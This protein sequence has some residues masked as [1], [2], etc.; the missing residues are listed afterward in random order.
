M[1]GSVLDCV[2][3]CISKMIADPFE[4]T[5]HNKMQRAITGEMIKEVCIPIQVDRLGNITE[6][7]QQ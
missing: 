7:G 2:Q 3:Y 6:I 1:S 5:R 4:Y